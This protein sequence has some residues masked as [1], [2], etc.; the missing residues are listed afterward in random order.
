MDKFRQEFEVGNLSTLL[1]EDQT[2][3]LNFLCRDIDGQKF[4]NEREQSLYDRL[5]QEITFIESE[6]VRMMLDVNNEEFS[7]REKK[8]FPSHLAMHRDM[9][10][11][12]SKFI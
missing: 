3:I 7:F 6:A 11:I 9:L 8:G 4:A 12:A 2:E 1:S 5:L 10:P